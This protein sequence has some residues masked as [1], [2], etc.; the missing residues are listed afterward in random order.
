MDDDDGSFEGYIPDTSDPGPILF[1][2][3]FFTF[4]FCLTV[5]PIAVVLGDKREQL[6]RLVS[7]GDDND[8]DECTGQQHSN[9]DVNEDD[10]GAS[11]SSKGT[12]YSAITGAAKEIYETMEQQ[13]RVTKQ[14]GAHKRHHRRHRALK[15]N[16]AEEEDD[17]MPIP[18]DMIA[19]APS[20][21]DDKDNSSSNNRDACEIYLDG[22]VHYETHTGASGVSEYGDDKHESNMTITA[23]AIVDPDDMINRNACLTVDGFW[24]EIAQIMAFDYEMKR[25]IKLSLPFATQALFTGVLDICTVGVIGKLV[26]TRA[27]SAFVVVN[28]LV[29]LTT[30]FCGGFHEALCTLCSQAI[31]AKKHRLAGKYVQIATV[32]YLVSYIPFGIIWAIYIG[33]AIEWFG[34][35]EETV[36]I[37]HQY[38]YLLI[39]DYLV[40]GFKEA[41]H[42]LLDVCG[43][44]NYSTA[45]GAAEE[46]AGFFLVLTWALL[47]APSLVLNPLFTIGV[48]HFTVAIFFLFLNILIIWRYGWFQLYMEGMIGTCALSDRKAVWMLSKTALALSFGYLLTDGEWE[49]LTIF[50][51][52]LGPAEVAA[53]GIFG[54]IWDAVN[55]LVDGIADA[56]E[57]RCAFLLGS[58]QPKRARLSAYKS[59]MIGV[60]TSLFVT[61][62][63]YTCGED[64]PTWLTNDPTLQQ[65]L[66]DLL[67]MFGLGNAAM[68][69]GTMSW[70][71]LGS[72]GRYRLATVIVCIISW[73]V[74]LPLAAICS[75]WLKIN[76]EGQTSAVVIGYTI[77]GCVHAYYL[78][79]SDWEALSESVMDDNDSRASDDINDLEPALATK[80]LYESETP[81]KA[82]TARNQ[83]AL[84]STGITGRWVDKNSKEN[85]VPVVGE[86]S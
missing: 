44:E 36:R 38:A 65:L 40:D 41:I 8:T 33:D 14:R 6:N 1:V 2:V 43:C 11:V 22:D 79:R 70:T 3:T 30:K 82:L 50:A 61:S 53:W 86:L 75:A 57:V 56:S 19:T 78:F 81:S 63:L 73:V 29:E 67:P 32:L 28:L 18:I 58:N 31:G 16:T 55:Q 34:F 7:S 80:T 24:D 54:T 39:I 45:I 47:G 21:P 66:R 77:S 84:S 60:F 15:I 69:I 5:L 23:A 37:G 27:V 17:D 59:M 9:D 72:Q 46:L 83:A 13:G 71:L 49:I 51:S 68:T 85:Q 64:L 20:T 42:A 48:I 4:I 12:I 76:L 35:D 62:A 74:T 25:I 52:F 26:G 10:D